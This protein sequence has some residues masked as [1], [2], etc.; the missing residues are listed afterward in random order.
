[1]MTKKTLVVGL[2]AMFSVTTFAQ[3]TTKKIKTFVHSP[4]ST[5]FRTDNRQ[6]LSNCSLLLRSQVASSSFTI[7]LNISGERCSA[8][9]HEATK[10]QLTH[11]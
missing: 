6:V 4:T 1:M 5:T 11:V 2:L 10:Q 9:P 8:T 3:T 7:R